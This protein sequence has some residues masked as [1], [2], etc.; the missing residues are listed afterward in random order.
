MSDIDTKYVT[1]RL[2]SHR[3]LKGGNIFR[4]SRNIKQADVKTGDC[5]SCENLSDLSKDAAKEHSICCILRKVR[6]AFKIGDFGFG[7]N[8]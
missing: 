5:G 7:V 6:E 3:D 8:L 1:C 4:T 2:R